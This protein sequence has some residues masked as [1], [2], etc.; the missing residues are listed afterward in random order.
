MGKPREGPGV[1]KRPSD[2]L[3]RELR[4]VSLEKEVLVIEGPCVAP[5]MGYVWF[6]YIALA[7]NS[8]RRE[9]VAA[10][11]NQS[12]GHAEPYAKDIESSFF[13]N[14]TTFSSFSYSMN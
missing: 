4:P 5:L 7:L 10:R 12:A 11:H 13:P 8:A 2:L 1:T 14:L 6:Q 3:C 9:V